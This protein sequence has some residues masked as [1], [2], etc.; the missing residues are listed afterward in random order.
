MAEASIQD[1]LSSSD[2]L[3][4][5]AID[6]LLNHREENRVVDYK[7]A[8]NTKDEIEWLNITKD[9]LAFAN[10]EGGYLVFGVKDGSYEMVNLDEE[11][12]KFLI[13]VNKVQQKL[14]RHISPLFKNLRT[15]GFER[16]GKKAIILYIPE[17]LGRTHIVIKDGFIKFPN[18][19][20]KFILRVGMIFIRKSGGNQIIDP[21]DFEWL[22]NRRIDRYKE[23]LLGKIAR[24]VEAPPEHEVLVFDTK[25]P[26]IDSNNQK[27]YRITSSPDSIPVKGLSFTIAPTTDEQL[28]SSWIALHQ[29]DSKFIPRL[30][31]ICRL[32]AK[33]HELTLNDEQCLWLA[34]FSLANGLPG[35]FWL[36]LLDKDNIYSAL[37]SAFKISTIQNR[38]VILDVSAFLGKTVYKKFLNK[39][40]SDQYQR[41][42]KRQLNYT[43]DLPASLFSP[44]LAKVYIPQSAKKEEEKKTVLENELTKV[45]TALATDKSDQ[46]VRDLTILLAI[47]CYLYS[48]KIGQRNKEIGMLDNDFINKQVY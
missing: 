13:D 22:I 11:D 15:K 7:E 5:D 14:N 46:L 25:S 39:F 35:F 33:R 36:S 1:Y 47:D 6:F 48:S 12:Y 21:D 40:P 34:I 32:Y 31:E 23:S 28:I 10:T 17:S 26:E 2:P 44:E 16:K 20:E 9:V 29:K 24:V 3:S 30:D 27:I 38:W 18:G 41:L 8:F 37:E 45:A 4:D 42:N 19:T 43:S